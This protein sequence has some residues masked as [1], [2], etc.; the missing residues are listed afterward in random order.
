MLR[1]F[2]DFKNIICHVYKWV[3]SPHL[4]L[5]IVIDRC[6]LAGL[7][8]RVGFFVMGNAVYRSPMLSTELCA[9]RSRTGW[10]GKGESSSDSP[11]M[12]YELSRATSMETF[13]WFCPHTLGRHPNFPKPPQRKKFLHKL[14]VKR[15]EY[16]PGVCGRNHW[17]FLLGL[18][19]LS[20]HGLLGSKGRLWSTSSSFMFAT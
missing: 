11:A 6:G 7:A 16:L 18:K 3:P 14:L 19:P 5:G 10:Q 9:V 4:V 15:P 17:S 12:L 2:I 1:N 13:Q 8:V 20:F